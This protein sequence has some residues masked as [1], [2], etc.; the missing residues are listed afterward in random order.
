MQ[1]TLNALPRPFPT[2]RKSTYDACGS[3][4]AMQGQVTFHGRYW[5]TTTGLEAII[6]QGMKENPRKAL[7]GNRT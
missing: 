4:C 5:K 1:Q 6:H 7:S 3:C 2:I